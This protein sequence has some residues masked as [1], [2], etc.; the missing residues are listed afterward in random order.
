MQPA[1][2]RAAVQ[3][4]AGV[5]LRDEESEAESEARFGSAAVSDSAAEAD[6][7]SDFSADQESGHGCAHSG[8]SG[9]SDG[10]A[11]TGE[12]GSDSEL[13]PQSKRPRHEIVCFGYP[14]AAPSVIRLPWQ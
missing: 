8:S 14:A 4:K 9:S 3:A 2:P 12:R 11:G 13:E 6:S 10:R 5:W 1:H 7:A